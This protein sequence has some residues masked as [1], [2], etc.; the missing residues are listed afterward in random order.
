M[1]FKEVIKNY[2]DGRAASD[3]LFAVS[4]AKGN[5]SIDECCRY[6]ISEARKL[7]TEVCM[8]DDEVF[9]MAVHYYDEDS[10]KVESAP[11]C[12]VKTRE[13]AEAR[14]PD[15]TKALQRREKK[16]GKNEFVQM[17]LF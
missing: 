6:I 14:Y 7:G 17:S 3:E 12:E 9:G 15:A 16:K 2:L 10:I 1:D 13:D 4:Y 5:K 8:S 11:K